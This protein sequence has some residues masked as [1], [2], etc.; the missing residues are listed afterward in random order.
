MD[1]TTAILHYLSM[2]GLAETD[3]IA[4]DLDLSRAQIEE[5]LED[6]NQKELVEH[7]GFWYLN[8]AGESHLNELLRDRFSPEAITELETRYSDFESLDIEFKDLANA[9]QNSKTN[10]EQQALIEDL[11]AFHSETRGFFEEFSDEIFDEYRRYL[12]ELDTALQRLNTGDSD[13]FTGTEVD[14]YHT[15]WFRLHD[16][17]MRTLDKDRD[18]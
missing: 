10:D 13:Y 16:D 12:E 11:E 9:W 15:V 8:D 4:E 14:S 6:L 17:L 5:V 7:E 2:E 3:Q 1:S 18:E